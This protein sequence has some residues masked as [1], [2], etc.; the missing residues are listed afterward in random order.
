MN[1]E[2]PELTVLNPA[3]DA[4][5]HNQNGKISGSFEVLTQNDSGP[6]YEDWE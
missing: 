2:T 4:I 1:Y 5:Q 6:A 3:I